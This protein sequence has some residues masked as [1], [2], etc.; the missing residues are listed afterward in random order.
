[1]QDTSKPFPLNAFRICIDHGKK[2]VLGTAFSPLTKYAIPFYG[3]GELLVKMDAIF[4][5]QGYPQSFQ[6]KRS[7]EK[8]KKL[9]NRYRGLPGYQMESKII[10]EKKGEEVTL[11]VMITARKN[12]S[13]QG[14]LLDLEGSTIQSFSGELALMDGIIN[15]IENRQR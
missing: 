11:D 2:D 4:D 15:Y 5:Q 8:E 14:Y 13:W 12:T 10:R 1:M 7:F 6:D 3:L 9:Q